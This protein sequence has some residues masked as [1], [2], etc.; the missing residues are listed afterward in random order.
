LTTLHNPTAEKAF[1]SRLRGGFFLPFIS[2]L[3]TNSFPPLSSSKFE[4]PAL[5]ADLPTR[6]V[7]NNSE[8]AGTYILEINLGLLEKIR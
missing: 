5:A 7:E 4:Q 3:R 6:P 8:V 1:I 2:E